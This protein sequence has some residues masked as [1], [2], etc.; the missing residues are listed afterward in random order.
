MTLRPLS[1]LVL[2][3]AASVAF[4]AEDRSRSRAPGELVELLAS[5]SY[6]V[7]E[8]A[9]FDLWALGDAAG[10]A[11]KEA[12]ASPNPE[13]AVRARSVLRKIHLGILPDSPP[14]VVDLVVR[15]ETANPGARLS[16]IRRLKQLRAWRQ[17]LRIHEL[18]RDPETLE[19]IAGEMAGVS[20][21]AA[22]EL[23]ASDT[24]DFSGA[25]ELLEMGRPE[26]EQLMSLADFHRVAGS[27]G[28]ELERASRLKGEAGHLWRYVL[29][30][31]NGDIRKAAEEARLSGRDMVG[32]RLLALEG[33]PLPWV[34][35]VSVPPQQI[36]PDS[37]D[38]YRAAVVRIWKGRG[39]SEDLARRLARE[40]GN[41]VVED[42]FG[43][44]SVLYALG[45]SD[46]ATETLA[47]NAPALAFFHHENNERVREAFDVMG[48]DPE[49][50]DFSGWAAERFEKVLGKPDAS[51]EELN[52]LAT[53][54][55]FLE[56][57]GLD[58]I[59]S[60]IFVD[61]LLQM[62][63][64]DPEVFLGKTNV[65]FSS[66]SFNRIVLPVL[67]ASAGFA[68]DDPNRWF[69]VRDNL[70]GEGPHVS[71]LW[72]SL[73]RLDP[74]M[75]NGAKLE[76]AAALVGLAPDRSGILE[77]WW[78]W[79]SEEVAKPD[80]KADG[81]LIAL[82]L[83]VSAL[84]S[85]GER[86]LEGIGIM[87]EAGLGYRDLGEL[88]SNFRFAGYELL[89]LSAAGK[90]DAVVETRLG[91]VERVPSDP[92]RRAY[93]AGALRK[94][95]KADEAAKQDALVER[96]ALGDV[97]DMRS[98]SS[99]YSSCG[100][101]EK[102]GVWL[103]RAAEQT[104]GDSLEFMRSAEPLLDDAKER[105]DW[106]L[107]ASLGEVQMLYH[108]MMGDLSEKPWTLLR[109]RIE[110]EMARAL[111]RMGEDRE[112][113][114]ATLDRCHRMGVT[115]GSMADYFFPALRSVGLRQEHDRWF[116]ETWASYV[117][118]IARF[119][120]S[121]NTR[122]TAAWT[123]ARANRRLDEA[124]KLIGEALEEM[125]DQAAYLDTCGEIWFCRR[126][127]EKALEWSREA[128]LHE[129]GERTLSRQFERFR[130]GEFPLR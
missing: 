70:L 124:E 40:A 123:A 26:P 14:E 105:G 106:R 73:G 21:M 67:Q 108:L 60:E 23:L 95:G 45:E 114:I 15:Y 99:A 7:R 28:N 20:V 82:M 51:D 77:R 46:L 66:F 61:P 32:A 72:D 85:D 129:P 84:R 43:A 10:S 90:W 96:L 107:A 79:S 22:R 5:E 116:E 104:T 4:A 31:A 3:L 16:I 92:V 89:C 53:L 86:F 12:V 37:L 128:L 57:R 63:H 130:T 19:R 87:R 47:A 75:E 9:T 13:V 39:V 122:N 34:A 125:P 94:A 97:R 54:G 80:G 117:E 50:P 81:E 6:P 42:R 58:A 64:D 30:A 103:R 127:R 101:F 2:A 52:D 35:G 88:G 1:T 59:A 115:D 56:R 38:A 112:A 121:Q 109:A 41:G 17:V 126:N 74:G 69:L 110:S 8:A 119:P 29:H 120:G 62:G 25:R 100:D 49:D 113:A 44:I 27:I 83:A 68:G 24:P 55:W 118:V 65:L 98:I 71:P 102:A 93:L 91:Q 76:A 11:L 33:D 18:E 78:K 36:A 48:L 111:S